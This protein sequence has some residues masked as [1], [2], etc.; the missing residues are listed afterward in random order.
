[1]PNQS[2]DDSNQ[3]LCTCGEDLE[4][5]QDPLVSSQLDEWLGCVTQCIHVIHTS[6]RTHIQ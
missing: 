6:I 5:L 3:D 4:S 2:Y 1:M